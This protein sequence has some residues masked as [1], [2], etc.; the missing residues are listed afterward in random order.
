MLQWHF[1]WQIWWCNPTFCM[2]SVVFLIMSI[3]F[4]N[5]SHSHNPSSSLLSEHKSPSCNE[6]FPDISGY[7]TQQSVSCLLILA[8]F[9][10]HIVSNIICHIHKLSS[11][12]LILA[13]FLHHI[14]SNNICHI[15]KLSSCLLILDNFLHHIVSNNTCHIHKPSSCLLILDNFLHI[16]SNNTCHIHKLSSC[17]HI[18]VNFLHTVS[19]NICHILN[20]SSC[21]NNINHTAAM[22]FPQYIWWHNTAI[23]AMLVHFFQL[24]PPCCQHQH[25]AK[26]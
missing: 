5:M 24:C 2:M 6:I 8:N 3:I 14:V 20:P 4:V 22:T 25:V 23:N 21:Q 9:L 1:L 7:V 10:H 18:L 15:H 17:L 19:N 12:L 13:N 26:L 11:G 16:V